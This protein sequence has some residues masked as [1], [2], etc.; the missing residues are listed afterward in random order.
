MQYWAGSY[1]PVSFSG[2]GEN[3]RICV[4]DSQLLQVSPSCA[5]SLPFL[6]KHHADT[7]AH[8]FIDA[9]EVR[10]HV[11][12]PPQLLRFPDPGDNTA[13]NGKRA[14]LPHSFVC[15]GNDL[16]IGYED[17]CRI[18]SVYIIVNNRI[19]Y[20]T[21]RSQE[22][23]DNQ[24]DCYFL[25]SRIEPSFSE[26]IRLTASRYRDILTVKG[27]MKYARIVTILWN[28]HQNV[29]PAK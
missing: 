17:L 19:Q 7:P 4:G 14:F 23:H 18:L 22:H 5:N 9:L 3:T 29:L 6:P 1:P 13:S 20:Q 26:K 27:A 2:V 15:L 21:K 11:R 24:N 16:L 12:Q 8:P 10:S 28:Y 25:S